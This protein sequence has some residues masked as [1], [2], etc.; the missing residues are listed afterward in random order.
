MKNFKLYL[1]ALVIFISV[2]PSKANTENPKTPI[3]PKT[4]IDIK[5]QQLINRLDE[6]NAMDKSDLDRS[7]KKELKKE[8]KVIKQQLQASGNGVYLSVGAVI[9]IILLLIL[10]L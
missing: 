6:I 1:A 10:L 4:T 9:I 8:V 7:A 2:V 3:A 5:T